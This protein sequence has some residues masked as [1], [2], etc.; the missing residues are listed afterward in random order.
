MD[1]WSNNFSII[2]LMKLL[3]RH[4]TL[5]E[6]M[7]RGEQDTVSKMDESS[8][9]WKSEQ[10]GITRERLLEE[11]AKYGRT[12]ERILAEEAEG[13]QAYDVCEDGRV[14]KAPEQPSFY[15]M[16]KTT[17]FVLEYKLPGGGMRIVA[18]TEEEALRTAQEIRND[19][20]FS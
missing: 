2:D 14:E 20:N 6:S 13:P 15:H 19:G 9:F 4:L 10:Y 11:I 8:I 16:R 17:P 12:A 3:R 5:I 18:W 1:N 7:K